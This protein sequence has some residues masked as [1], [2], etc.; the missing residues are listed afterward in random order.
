MIYY[1]EISLT[2]LC[3]KSFKTKNLSVDSTYTE[4]FVILA[5]KETG[6]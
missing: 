2:G 5:L 3:G 6:I 1:S 4:H